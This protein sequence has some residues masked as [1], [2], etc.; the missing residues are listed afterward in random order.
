MIQEMGERRKWKH[1][2]TDEANSEYQRLNNKQRKT[3]DKAREI[4][5]EEKCED[6][7]E[8]QAKRRHDTVYAKIKTL[9]RK[10]GGNRDIAIKDRS[11][12]LLQNLV[13]VRTRWKEYIEELYKGVDNSH[14]YKEEEPQSEE[15]RMIWG[16]IS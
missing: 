9:T 14:D 10:P 16:R 6:L 2:S 11:G 4:W 12:K 13:E 1:Q 5:W 15:L 8:L 7:E 3:T